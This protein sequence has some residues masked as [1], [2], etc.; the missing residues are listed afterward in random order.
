MPGSSSGGS[1][2]ALA[3]SLGRPATP[4]AGPQGSTGGVVRPVLRRVRSTGWVP[5]EREGSPDLLEGGMRS[6]AA[7]EVAG[8]VGEISGGGE[9]LEAQ[10]PGLVM[11]EGRMGGVTGA[12][13]PRGG[14]N[15]IAAVMLKVL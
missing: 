13:G 8:S 5:V 1:L 10:S 6:G 15:V 14:D 9:L 2:A 4:P 7:S 3:G 11:P 12:G